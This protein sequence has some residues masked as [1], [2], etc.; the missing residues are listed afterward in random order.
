M[1]INKER[2][3]PSIR[4]STRE[5][6]YQSRI[7]RKTRQIVLDRDQYI[8]QECKRNGRLA[9]TGRTVDHIIGIKSGGSVFGLHNLEVL[10][11]GCHGRKSQGEK[12]K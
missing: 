10:C 2:T 3:R 5:K 6:V 11:D 7:W 9:V 1:R 4:D 12:R 8:C